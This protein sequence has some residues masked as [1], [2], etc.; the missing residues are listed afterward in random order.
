MTTH[1]FHAAILLNIAAASVT[2]EDH[3]PALSDDLWQRTHRVFAYESPRRA[4][5][6]SLAENQAGDLILL[7]T[8]VT[9]DQEAAGVGD[10]MLIRS[11]DR[12]E[13]WSA[14]KT[15]YPGKRGEPRT[16]GTLTN[17]AA[18]KLIAMATEKTGDADDDWQVRLLTSD[19]GGAHWKTTDLLNLAG[20][21]NAM[22]YGRLIERPNGELLMAVQGFLS[23]DDG[24]Q[25]PACGL[26]RSHDGGRSWHD[27]KLIAA[28]F[29]QPAV[30]AIADETLVATICRG[31]QLFRCT[32][33]D[34]GRRWTRPEQFFVGRE[35]QMVAISPHALACVSTK[36]D[37]WSLILAAFSYDAG[38][39]WRCDRKVAEHPGQPGGHLGWPV[40]WALDDNHMVV[41]FGNT[42]V[43]SSVLDGPAGRSIA[44]EEERIE[45]VFFERDTSGPELPRA[46]PVIHPSQRDS[47]K[48]ADGRSMNLPRPFVR[49]AEE[50]IFGITGR[51][52]ETQVKSSPHRC[53]R[54]RRRNG[55]KNLAVQGRQPQLGATTDQPAGRFPWRARQRHSLDI[56]ANLVCDSG[57]DRDG[58]E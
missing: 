6:P 45:V 51:Q 56:G 32:S 54:V 50:E 39:T 18:G 19:D 25:E 15:I 36:G 4:R 20:L 16:M 3:K 57:M 9:V 42:Q 7:F 34:G 31:E 30:L 47:W 14:P 5:H 44:I 23:G 41:A 2:A 49:T 55:R 53:V 10:L 48:L 37:R 11:T 22:P 58:V 33:D 24:R 8:R 28:G 35:P 40:A 29:Q 17:L 12:G 27:F 38:Q 26:L 1:F 13:S 46:G 21:R 52:V 43:P